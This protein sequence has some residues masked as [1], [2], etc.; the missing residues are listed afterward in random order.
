[1]KGN[2]IV[3]KVPKGITFRCMEENGTI[4]IEDIHESEKIVSEYNYKNPIIPK[5]FTYLKGEWK[6]G[7]TIRNLVDG[8]DFVWV[9]VG[10]L[11]KDGT[12]DGENFNQSFGRRNFRG[13]EFS[14][15]EFHETADLEMIESFKKYGGYYI[16]AYLASVENGKL[17]FKKGNMPWGNIS[18]QKAKKAAKNYAGR[19]SNIVTCLPSGA[20]YDTIF[21]WIIQSGEKTFKAFY[22]ILKHYDISI[23]KNA[24]RKGALN[25]TLIDTSSDKNINTQ[26]LVNQIQNNLGGIK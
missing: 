5:G 23:I 21:K 9:P 13:E 16:S 7:F 1:M 26:A 11:E 19:N 15:K 25:N 17:V 3:L 20:A 4:V 18:Q 14:S 24:I 10:Y 2:K 22:E 8:S 6:K 12:I